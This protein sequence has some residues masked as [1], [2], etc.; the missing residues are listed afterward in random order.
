M[1]YNKHVHSYTVS[2]LFFSQQLH[3]YKTYILLQS[4]NDVD[5]QY[6]V[7]TIVKIKANVMSMIFPDRP[8]DTC[9]VNLN[10][11]M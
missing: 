2:Y 3:M 10:C 11:K 1:L 8:K 6:R 4:I 9:P 5:I 7:S